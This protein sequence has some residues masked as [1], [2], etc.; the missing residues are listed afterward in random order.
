MLVWLNDTGLAG[1]LCSR[2]HP[3]AFPVP[4][5]SYSSQCTCISTV[6]LMSEHFGWR[7]R[8]IKEASCL[9]LTSSP[10]L[11]LW[12][13]LSSRPLEPLCSSCSCSWESRLSSSS[14]SLLW[15]SRSRLNPP[16]PVWP[17]NVSPERKL[18]SVTSGEH[19]GDSEERDD[20]GDKE[21]MEWGVS[22]SLSAWILDDPTSTPTP[23]PPPAPPPAEHPASPPTPPALPSGFPASLPPQPVTTSCSCM[24]VMELEGR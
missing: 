16:G 22:D 21:L 14:A 12:F 17:A 2:L 8:R 4:L 9:P 6:M 7:R 23:P 24:V 13:R 15:S 1:K 11:L 18:V 20:R 10:S 3:P 19:G 5:D